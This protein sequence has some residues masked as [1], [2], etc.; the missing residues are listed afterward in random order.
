MNYKGY[1]GYIT[2]VGHIAENALVLGDEFRKG[3]VA[4]ATKK[5]LL[6]KYCTR[7]MLKVRRIA[8]LRSDN[9]A[10]QADIIYYCEQDRI[11]FAIGADCDKVVLEAIMTISMR[12]V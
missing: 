1:K 6:Y 10:Y 2:I 5:T 11:A 4:P 12:N 7:Q 8:F 9:A 3:N